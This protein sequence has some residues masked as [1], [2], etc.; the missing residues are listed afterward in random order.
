MS[1]SAHRNI[2]G[3]PHCNR[4]KVL[5]INPKMLSLGGE[6][7]NAK[8]LIDRRASDQSVGVERRRSKGIPVGWFC[9]DEK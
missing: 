9:S 2:E 6:F 1:Y 3:C 8:I 5:I 4:Q 7:S